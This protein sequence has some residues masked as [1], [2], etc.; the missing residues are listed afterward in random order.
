MTAPEVEQSLVDLAVELATGAGALT[1][2]WFDRGPVDFDTKDDGSPV[3][4]EDV[5]QVAE[6]WLVPERRVVATLRRGGER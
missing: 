5:R 3:T 1:R 2:K 6:R 4:A